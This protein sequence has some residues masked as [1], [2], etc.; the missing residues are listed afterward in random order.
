MPMSPL[1]WGCCLF[2]LL[3][4]WIL[5]EVLK[6]Y[7]I[8]LFSK[9]S[10]S[11]TFQNKI[12]L[13]AALI[14][15]LNEGDGYRVPCM[16]KRLIFLFVNYFRNISVFLD[17][18]TLLLSK[19]HIVFENHLMPFALARCQI[20]WPFL[21]AISLSDHLLRLFQVLWFYIVFYFLVIF[22][23]SNI[24]KKGCL[25]YPLVVIVTFS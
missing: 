24:W 14:N 10:L 7:V 16:Y 22:F 17:K 20:R 21:K 15:R 4:T 18:F 9:T 6:S 23:C 12:T 1:V 3:P 2:L 8:I 5:T 13:E 19:T 25:L 11:L